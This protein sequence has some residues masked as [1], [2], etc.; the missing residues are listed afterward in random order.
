[1]WKK[2]NQNKRQEKIERHYC[3][4]RKMTNVW[5]DKMSKTFM[6]TIVR[7]VLYASTKSSQSGNQPDFP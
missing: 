2:K 7:I 3:L 6:N 5:Y 1:M 4:Y